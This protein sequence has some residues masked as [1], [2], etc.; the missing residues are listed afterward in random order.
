MKKPEWINNNITLVWFLNWLFTMIIL[1]IIARGYL[2]LYDS[3]S[4]LQMDYEHI[5]N[6]YW[7]FTELILDKISGIGGTFYP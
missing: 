1:V 6:Q 3:Y 2:G 4:Q 7:L 5:V